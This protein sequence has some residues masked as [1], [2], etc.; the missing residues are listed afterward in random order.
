MLKMSTGDDAT[1]GNYRKIAVALF[2]E[3]NKAVKFLDDRIADSPNGENE[4][5]IAAESQM[6]YLLGTLATQ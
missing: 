6:V 2:G 1:L 3:G 5:V 4:E